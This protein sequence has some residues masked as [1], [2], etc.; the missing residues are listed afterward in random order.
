MSTRHVH[1]SLVLSAATLAGCGAETGTELALGFATQANEQCVFRPDADLTLPRGV[2]DVL[3]A[4]NSTAFTL[5]YVVSNGL[6]AAEDA[7]Y[8]T[9]DGRE[10]RP[11]SARVTFAGFDVCWVRGDDPDVESF[12]AYSQGAPV[13]CAELPYDQKRFVPTSGSIAPEDEVGVAIGS[14]LRVSDLRADGI[15]GPD[16]QPANIPRLGIYDD[17]G[18][19]RYSQAADPSQRNAA[20]GDFPEDTISATV[21]LQMRLVGKNQAGMTI[22]SNWISY[23]VDVCL[24]CAYQACGQWTESQA[25]ACPTDQSGF[26]GQAI[27]GANSCLPAQLMRISCTDREICVPNTSG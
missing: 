22:R 24:G 15:F 26:V 1:L 25:I 8:T 5:G 4:G 6:E 14:I 20:W 19:R 11:D 17:G 9:G 12:G 23:P 7:Q 27:D 21:L 10:L 13:D 3:L 2:F 18:V 16:F